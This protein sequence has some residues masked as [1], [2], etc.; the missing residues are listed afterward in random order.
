MAITELI[1]LKGVLEG[2]ASE[3]ILHLGLAAGSKWAV[4]RGTRRAVERT[5]AAHG[6]HVR[7]ALL[8][9]TQH[10]EIPPR[11]VLE[12]AGALADGYVA[13]FG[14]ALALTGGARADA[15]PVLRDFFRSLLELSLAPEHRL[16]DARA[17]A[18]AKQTDALVQRALEHTEALA[19]YAKRTEEAVDRIARD[20]SAPDRAGPRIIGAPVVDLTTFVGRRE[21]LERLRSTLTGA[22]PPRVLQLVGKPGFGKSALASRLLYDLA[23]DERIDAIVFASSRDPRGLSFSRLAGD[24]AQL[25]STE[26]AARIHGGVTAGIPLEAKTAILV[27]ELRASRLLI[28]LDDLDPFLDSR[29]AL[30]DRELREIVRAWANAPHASTIVL[31]AQIAVEDLPSHVERLDAPLPAEQAVSVLRELMQRAGKAPAGDD[32]LWRLNEITGGVPR[33]LELVSRDDAIIAEAA[34]ANGPE[35][36]QVRVATDLLQD[37][38]ARLSAAEQDVVAA[39]SVFG[40]PVPRAAAAALS[41]VT[42]E[43]VEPLIA[44]DIVRRGAGETLTLHPLDTRFAYGRLQQD[45]DRLRALERAAA[46]W[47]RSQRKP[48]W[49]SMEDVRPNLLEWEHAMRAGD[50]TRAVDIVEELDFSHLSLWGEWHRLLEMRMEIPLDELDPRRRALNVRGIGAARA[51]LGEPAVAIGFYEKALELAE[52][53]GDEAV[54]VRTEELRGMAFN[55]IGEYASAE[56][57]LRDVLHRAEALQDEMEIGRAHGALGLAYVGLGEYGRAFEHYETALKF[58]EKVEDRRGLV[59]R[60]TNSAIA[61]LHVGEADRALRDLDQAL[62][63]AA[64]IHDVRGEERIWGYIGRAWAQLGRLELALRSTTLAKSRA[65]DL[66]DR[67]GVAFHGAHRSAVLAASGDHDAA[68]ACLEEAVT[69]ARSTSLHRLVSEAL[70]VRGT[71]LLDRDETAAAVRAF[72]AAVQASDAVRERVAAMTGHARMA[73]ASGAFSKAVETAMAAIDSRAPTGAAAAATV[74]ARALLHLGH[75]G[76]AVELLAAHE[77]RASVPIAAEMALLRAIA[78]GA[79]LPGFRYALDVANGFSAASGSLSHDALFL[80]ALAMSPLIA[81]GEASDELLAECM[82]DA[83]ARCDAAGV[84]RSYGSLAALL[85]PV[86]GGAAETLLRR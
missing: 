25:A 37:A 39:L 46:D 77:A 27:H 48:A 36:C 16:L 4:V 23:G 45:P 1:T 43:I 50:Y 3:A 80:A 10:T 47:Y 20:S 60:L 18:R 38:Y 68:L 64:A 83:L 56:A 28:L 74:A 44:R 65:E 67:T 63:L 84:R 73:L 24:L 34:R 40:R 76:E 30:R 41:A 21:H 14:Q 22:S 31:T 75:A 17:E 52:Q 82:N 12:N 55:H 32:V 79:A 57:L 11:T 5:V 8:A 29:G 66:F 2:V 49:R 9:W 7:Q 78:G 42:G 6:K 26:G 35:Q 85:T 51:E 59:R 70:T 19:G 33:S 58:G 53:A 86:D 81:A 15:E 62:T 54:I 69:L 13:A 72:D 61:R 71:I